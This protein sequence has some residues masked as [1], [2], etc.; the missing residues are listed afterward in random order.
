V[1]EG[2]WSTG[3]VFEYRFKLPAPRWPLSYRGK[4]FCFEW[5]LRAV[6]IGSGGELQTAVPIHSV[7]RSPGLAVVAIGEKN[8]HEIVVR[9]PYR[10][11]LVASFV[12][13]A[14]IALIVLGVA[15]G[16]TALIPIGSII[17]LFAL[18]PAIGSFWSVMSTRKLLSPKK[19]GRAEARVVQSQSPKELDCQLWTPTDDSVSSVAATLMVFEVATL[20]DGEVSHQLEAIVHEKTAE[21][22]K[23]AGPGE[24]AGKLPLPDP[25]HVPY[26]ANGGNADITWLVRFRTVPEGPASEV[27]VV[28]LIVGPSDGPQPALRLHAVQVPKGAR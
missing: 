16:V 27:V 15:L 2:S 19:S 26:S 8:P 6:A 24:W 4:L 18:V 1:F 9:P 13:G 10:T 12:L 17:G 3:D 28:P 25:G 5:R 7:C 22:E 21:L 20:I 23:T 11:L 14:A